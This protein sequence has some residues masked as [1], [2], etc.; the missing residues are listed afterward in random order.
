MVESQQLCPGSSVLAV[1][2]AM[3]LCTSI[4]AQRLGMP[5]LKVILKCTTA[6]CQH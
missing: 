2:N 1:I 4:T 6:Y 5:L 3:E